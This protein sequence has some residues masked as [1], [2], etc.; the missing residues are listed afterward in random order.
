MTVDGKQPHVLVVDDSPEI[1]S[2]I[3]D[4][5]EE[6]LLRVTTCSDGDVDLGKLVG[7][8]PDLILL[9]PMSGPAEGLLQHL[10]GDARSL[11]IPII[12]CTGAVRDEVDEM[13]ERWGAIA[14]MIV[15]KPF[16]IDHL[17][18]LV[19]AGLGLPYEHNDLSPPCQEL[20]S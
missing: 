4:L 9:D 14:P 6:E 13:G 2:L 19:Q 5:L 8:A 16:D 20:N 11:Q 17:L 7:I 3:R 18:G 10:I 12:F 1:L 15:R